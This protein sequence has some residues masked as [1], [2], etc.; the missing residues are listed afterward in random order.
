MDIKAIKTGFERQYFVSSMIAFSDLIEQYVPLPPAGELSVK[1]AMQTNNMFKIWRDACEFSATFN[2]YSSPLGRYLWENLDDVTLSNVFGH[3][4]LRLCFSMNSEEKG[5]LKVELLVDAHLDEDFQ[6]SCEIKSCLNGDS[7]T[8][9]VSH[10]YA[11]SEIKIIGIVL[12]L[13]HGEGIS[14]DNDAF[15]LEMLEMI[16][17]NTLP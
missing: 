13:V 16:K 4:T 14:L 7:D 10:Y 5:Q 8:S 17:A 9:K 11:E 2:K 1:H 15:T 3:K 6:Y 12:E